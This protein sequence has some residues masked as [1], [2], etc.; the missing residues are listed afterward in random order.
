MAGNK[1]AEPNLVLFQVLYENLSIL[2]YISYSI[3]LGSALRLSTA[4]GAQ[5]EPT[6]DLL[7][8]PGTLLEHLPRNQSREVEVESDRGVDGGGGSWGTWKD[9]RMAL[10]VAK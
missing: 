1:F 9:G 2:F 6:N 8:H 3:V 4:L 5:G 7:L 10:S